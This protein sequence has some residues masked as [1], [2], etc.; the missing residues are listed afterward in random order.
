MLA[1]G[2]KEIASDGADPIKSWDW[3][4]WSSIAKPGTAMLM[5]QQISS[6]PLSTT[7]SPDGWSILAVHPLPSLTPTSLALAVLHTP[8]GMSVSDIDL[9][10]ASPGSEGDSKGW[11][12][13]R[14]TS[15]SI[16]EELDL[17]EVG[18]VLSQGAERGEQGL[19]GITDRGVGAI[20]LA[21][22]KLPSKLMLR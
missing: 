15:I 9:L 11:S 1:D 18:L 3:V 4:S 7:R 17:Y 6:R 19:I 16:Q 12:A 5:V 2:F 20:L 13:M 21:S 8:A 10:N 14:G 22:P